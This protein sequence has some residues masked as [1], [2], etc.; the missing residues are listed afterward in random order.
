MPKAIEMIKAKDPD[1]AIMVGGAPMT[2]EI[3]TSYGA[4]GYADNAGEAV[5]EANEM[6]KRLKK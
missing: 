6:L 2:R 4:D 3:A 5:W 1:V